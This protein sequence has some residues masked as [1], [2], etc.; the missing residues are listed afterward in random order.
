VNKKTIK[1]FLSRFSAVV[2]T[3]GSSGI[4]E[5]FF[6]AIS[7]LNDN[8]L[9]CNL[10]RSKPEIMGDK[11]GIIHFPCDFSITEELDSQCTQLIEILTKKGGSG[12]ILLINNSGFG[13]YGQFPEPDGE[14]QVNMLA[15]N[16]CAP[17]YLTAR[18]MPL[19]TK[20]GGVILNVASTAAFQPLP[21]MSTYAASKAFL[22][23]WSLALN[24]D[25]KGTG[26]S[27]LVLCPGPTETHFFTRAGFT[28][29]P[30]ST[31][32]GQTAEEVVET[33]LYAL[34]KGK[35]LTVSGW[36]NRLLVFFSSKLPKLIVIKMAAIGLRLARLE[37]FKKNQ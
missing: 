1:S 29:S 37:Q 17:V 16:V 34:V 22:M 19:L 7:S 24:E 27:T 5:S 10:S 2:I 26:I 9:Y 33:A 13:T 6:K 20:R 23:H 32:P 15:V 31:Y 14:T 21:F 36:H 4:G 30:M 35:S 11:C 8:A 18:L 3:G 25:L 12:K 28:E